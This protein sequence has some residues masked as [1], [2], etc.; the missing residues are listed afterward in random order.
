MTT[1]NVSIAA[2]KEILKAIDDLALKRKRSRS[3]LYNEAAEMLLANQVDYTPRPN[4]N[5]KATK[6]AGAK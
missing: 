1:K 6:K 5:P 3:F 4:H 2:N